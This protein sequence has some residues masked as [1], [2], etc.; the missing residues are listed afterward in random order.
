MNPAYRHLEEPVK[1]GDFTLGQL[2]GFLIAAMV[3]MLWGFVLSPFSPLLTLA[4]SIYVG[5]LP[6]MAVFFASTTD[7]NVIRMVRA[8]VTFQRRPGR[9]LPGPGRL[10]TAGYVV[11]RP[12]RSPSREDADAMDEVL[13]GDALW[14]E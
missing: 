4:T 8:Y 11:K 7:V 2:A 13:I 3:A 5:G 9:F 1:V 14:Q 10:E 6:A 12:T